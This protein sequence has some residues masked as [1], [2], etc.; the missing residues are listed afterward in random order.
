MSN[1]CVNVF[2]CKIIPIAVDTLFYCLL[3]FKLLFVINLLYM[4]FSVQ[5]E[6]H[7]NRNAL[8]LIA[9][10]RGPSWS[11][12]SV[13]A[14]NNILEDRSRCRQ[15]I[16][17]YFRTNWRRSECKPPHNGQLQHRCMDSKPSTN[18]LKRRDVKL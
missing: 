1:E 12:A 8:I 13:R 10:N 18:A 16:D 7:G 17:F 5:C 14:Q 6:R 2:R 9:A 15:L 11:S 4:N 3:T